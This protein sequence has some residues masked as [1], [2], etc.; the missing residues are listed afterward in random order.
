MNI[1]EEVNLIWENLNNHKC[2][3][4][5]VGR[6]IPFAY[7]QDMK[8]T[9]KLLEPDKS[10]A[11]SLLEKILFVECP[12]HCEGPDILFCPGCKG[13]KKVETT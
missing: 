3:F 11:I 1:E 2:E 8:A 13:V 4:I 12:E 7:D 9:Q 5:K 6:G 10:H